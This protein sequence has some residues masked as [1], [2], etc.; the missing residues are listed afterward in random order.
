MAGFVQIM[1]WKT[2]KIDEVTKLSEEY[3]AGRKGTG[4]GPT[5]VQVLSDRDNP[6]TYYTVAE[7]ESVEVAEENSARA[8]TNEFAKKL[9]ELC[10][11]PPTFHNTEVIFDEA[12]R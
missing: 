1:Q 9:V 5:R 7:F 2:S 4:S 11:G 10:D 8:D 6:N 3:R 12:M